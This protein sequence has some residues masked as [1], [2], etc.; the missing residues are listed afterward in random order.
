MDDCFQ[1]EIMTREKV[2]FRGEVDYVKLPGWEGEIGVLKNHAPLIALLQPGEC[3]LR[4]NKK[5]VFMAIGDGFA[6]I[7]DNNVLV[8]VSFARDP[9]EIDVEEAESVLKEEEA[10]FKGHTH[11]ISEFDPHRLR[12]L[13]AKACLAV[14]RG[15]E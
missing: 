9:E 12:L 15:K 2:K 10:Y 14:A 5:D 13:R 8:L 1:I 3:K 4:Y 11:E 7:R 6:K